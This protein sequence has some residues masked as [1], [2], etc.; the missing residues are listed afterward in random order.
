VY[1]IGPTGRVIALDRA[2]GQK[3]NSFWPGEIRTFSKKDEEGSLLD[4][5]SGLFL[6]GGTHFASTNSHRL[7]VWELA[8]GRC[9]RTIDTVRGV[10]LGQFGGCL[11]TARP[12]G[13]RVVTKHAWYDASL[14][15]RLAEWDW[16]T[17][18]LTGAIEE[19]NHDCAW[20]GY[21]PDGDGLWCWS[22]E[23]HGLKFWDLR[24]GKAKAVL[25]ELKG[26]NGCLAASSDGRQLVSDDGRRV[27][28]H[29]PVSGQA[30]EPKVYS[31][32]PTGD[33]LFFPDGQRL[34][35]YSR[36]NGHY[37]EKN[38]RRKAKILDER[39]LFIWDCE[40]ERL[41]T[42]AFPHG[43]RKLPPGKRDVE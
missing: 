23:T 2:T 40:A 29:D 1:A 33:V 24:T 9:V 28:M 6:P 36:P 15:V 37:W 17:G 25:P 12:D 27:R 21:L 19:Q 42:L 13:A 20:G 10:D 43:M 8:T 32:I 16:R 38:D 14:H 3:T 31:E 7:N 11:L 35:I 5:E 18:I 30:I 22:D 41:T 34:L 39:M 4:M 26:F